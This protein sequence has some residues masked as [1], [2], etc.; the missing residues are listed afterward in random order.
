MTAI[1]SLSALDKDTTAALVL[2]GRIEKVVM[3]ERLTRRKHQG[4]FPSRSIE[5][6]FRETGLRPEQVDLVTYPFFHWSGEA[7]AK[8]EGYLRDL[9]TLPA[10]VARPL[11]VARH[12]ATY[13]AWL[14]LTSWRHRGYNAELL[15][16]LREQGLAGRPLKYLPHHAT[17]AA[18]A[19][20]C[21]SFERALIATFDWYGSGLAGT[22]WIGE[23]GRMRLLKGMFYPHSLGLFYAS[24][25][26]GLGFRWSNHEGKIVGLAAYGDPSVLLPEVLARFERPSG[27]LKLLSGMDLDYPR[28]LAGRHRR[29]DVAAA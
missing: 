29:E 18:S 10:R 8:I 14:L 23:A 6:L 19:Y 9:A 1:L 22:I 12:Q 13:L 20:F 5:I 27:D 28:R 21:S 25:T 17:H 4:G 7:R 24:V 11:E 2:D 26:R 15:R 16:G 3:E